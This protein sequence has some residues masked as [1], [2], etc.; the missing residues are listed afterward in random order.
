MFSMVRRTAEHLAIRM[1]KPLPWVGRVGSAIKAGAIAAGLLLGGGTILGIAFDPALALAVVLLAV[2]G[3]LTVAAWGLQRE[4]DKR[5]EPSFDCTT[6]LEP[7]NWYV[8]PWNQRMFTHASVAWVTVRNHGSTSE[9]TARIRDVEGV[10][11]HWG[12]DQ[13][14]VVR[15]PLWETP[16]ARSTERIESGGSRRLKLAAI[17]KDPRAFWFYTSEAGIQDGP[18]HQ[19]LLGSN[20]TADIRFILEIVNTGDADQAIQGTGCFEI[21]T[22]VTRA[23]FSL[24]EP[25]G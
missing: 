7:V 21:P 13:S 11:P 5:N 2:V 12:D 19:L 4:L 1:A 23:R 24:A 14:Y 20:D 18:G 22:D 10:P 9:F 6:H 15:Q 3:L 16:P 25:L 8:G 17:L